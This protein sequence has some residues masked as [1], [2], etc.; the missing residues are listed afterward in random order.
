MKDILRIASKLDESG[1]FELSDK[2]MKIAQD[3]GKLWGIFPTAPILAPPQPYSGGKSTAVLAPPV[4]RTPVPPLNPAVTRTPVAPLNRPTTKSINSELCKAVSG[5][6][7][8]DIKFSKKLIKD[9]VD[10]KIE[11]FVR[12]TRSYEFWECINNSQKYTVPQKKAYFDQCWRI[13]YESTDK[14]KTNFY[15]IFYP[16]LKKYKLTE[17][18]LNLYKT[19]DEVGRQWT[20][21]FDE[22]S[23][24]YGTDILN[25]ADWKKN[26]QNEYSFIFQTFGMT[27]ERFIW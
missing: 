14:T 11:P 18:D 9:E 27:R 10:R 25:D 1:Q 3:N 7:Y 8:Y 24:I 6:Y 23:K 20:K 2:L 22:L 26:N 4:T 16:L 13:V 17:N 19:E 21:V 5:T 12:G 15:Q